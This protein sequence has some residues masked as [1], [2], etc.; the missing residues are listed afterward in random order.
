MPAVADPNDLT[1]IALFRGLTSEQLIWL[2]QR[3][4]RRR[5]AAGSRLL[6][7]EQPGEVV[8]IIVQGT[9]K[10]YVEQEDGSRVIVAFRGR[11]D[12]IGEISVVDGVGRSTS[13][14]TMETS[15][16]L[17]MDG[18]TFQKALQTMPVMAN[19][20]VQIMAR[21]LRE[22]TDQIQ[23]LAGQDAHGRMARLL[24]TLAQQHGQP[25]PDGAMR[26][27]LRLTQSDLADCVGISRVH[28]NKIVGTYQGLGYISI[29]HD[30]H[31]TLHDQA[32]LID[33]C[34]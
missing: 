3:I 12:P 22:A 20:L 28:A 8:Y 5:F 18:S 19:N 27:P 2:N 32:A 11:G 1:D 4:H 23:A 34:R 30:R 25:T 6:T 13:V 14:E 24:L 33:R 31:I 26:I 15:T 7:A 21:R 17:W 9:A 16:L 10:V 29:D